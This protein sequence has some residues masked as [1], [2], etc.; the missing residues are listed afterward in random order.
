MRISGGNTQRGDD[1]ASSPVRIGDGDDLPGY[2]SV[3]ATQLSVTSGTADSPDDKASTPVRV[4]RT[5]KISSV[6]LTGD[7]V[8]SCSALVGTCTG[9]AGNDGQSVG[10]AGF[11]KNQSD[12]P[13]S[14][15]GDDAC[16]LY[17]VGRIIDTGTGTGIGG[18]FNGRRDTNT[19]RA[20]GIEVSS[21]NNTA[22]AGSYSSSGFSD[23]SGVWCHATG[24][25][26]SGA[27]VVVGN[28]FGV[29]F[30]VGYAINGQVSGGKTGG[31]AD[32]GWR[33]DGNET[34]VFDAN[35]SHTDGFDTTG[36]TFTG[37]AVKLG[38]SHGIRYGSGG[39]ISRA[40]SGSPEG[41][42]TA[43]VGSDYRRTDGG[44]GTSHYFKESGSGNTGW[45]AK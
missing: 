45:V 22:S 19:A 36:A 40:G 33:T 31:V 18:F 43:P 1:F 2:V 23:T 32:A 44:A 13:A 27:G 16:G 9:T 17:G 35:G 14:S 11:A 15:G 12:S 3:P 20:N 38:A 39:P 30:K 24:Q 8:D 28:P 6:N 5:L 37:D 34:T 10:I 4:S 7:G 42:V 26:D 41:V 21:D 25:S 29:Q